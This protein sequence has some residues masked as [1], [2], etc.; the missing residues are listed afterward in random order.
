MEQGNV[1]CIDGT[2]DY[3][4]SV[5]NGSFDAHAFYIIGDEILKEINILLEQVGNNG[6]DL[7]DEHV[8]KKMR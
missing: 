7:D 2:Q 1:S 6:S 5:P 3:F 4:G 8:P